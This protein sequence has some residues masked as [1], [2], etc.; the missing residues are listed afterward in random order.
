MS[1]LRL[2]KRTEEIL[3]KLAP[4]HFASE[5]S[6]TTYETVKKQAETGTYHVFSGG[7]TDTIFSERKYQY[8]YRAWHDSIHL[9][10]EIPFEMEDELQVARLQEHYALKAGVDPDDAM[11]LR[12][13]LECH[14]RY[15]YAKGEHPNAQLDLI[16]DCLRNGI[17]ET[18]NSDKI[19]H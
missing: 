12:Y 2:S 4:K 13:D 9:K 8:A 19:Y 7:S 5:D 6:P 14:I 10:H 11:M 3:L 15:Y 17:N 18:V 16:G 1:A